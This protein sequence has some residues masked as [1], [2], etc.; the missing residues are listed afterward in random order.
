M[1]SG[2]LTTFLILFGF[3]V[4]PL[5]ASAAESLFTRIIYV[6]LPSFTRVSPPRCFGHAVGAD[7]QQ[8]VVEAA[9]KPSDKPWAL[10]VPFVCPHFPLIAPPEFFD[11]Y[12]LD[13]SPFPTGRELASDHPVLAAMREN[14][15]YDGHFRDDAHI[16]TALAAY[17]GM[18]SFQDDN[19]GRLLAA[20]EVL[21]G[22]SGRLH[23]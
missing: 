15:N 19:V 5:P 13:T 12:P 11:L 9:E 23:R 22:H 6:R 20:L 4:S 8:V 14:F 2:A 16:R 7:P 18:V 17:Y 3:G 10:F 1:Y 21:R